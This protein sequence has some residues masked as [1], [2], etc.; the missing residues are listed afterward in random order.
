ME[1]ND[2]IKYGVPESTGIENIKPM[3]KESPRPR[4]T[5]AG[6]T[7]GSTAITVA[8][9]NQ[10]KQNP[11][12]WFVWKDG[13]KTGGDTGQALRTLTGDYSL[14]GVDRGTLAYESTARVNDNGT[15]TVY[16]R[17]V[18]ENRQYAN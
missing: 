16:V 5:R 17:Y 6:R 13:A 15:W 7:G 11:G 2:N 8:R 9:R 3:V 10:L 4:R 14:K 1:Y 12:E 18:G